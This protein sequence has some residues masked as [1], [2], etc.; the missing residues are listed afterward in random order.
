MSSPL[1]RVSP[2]DID[3][4]MIWFPDGE[5]VDIWG[6]PRFRYPFDRSTFHEDCRWQEFSSYCV[7]DP[8]GD[9]VAFG[10]IGDR[11]DRAH[12]AR[13]VVHPAH[14]GRGIGRQLLKGLIEIAAREGRY[15]SVALFVYRHNEVALGCYLSHGFEIQEYPDTA[16]MKDACFYLA[17]KIDVSGSG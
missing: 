2:A 6:G 8:E 14:R 1:D 3:E 5:S 17:R 10:Q 11:Y 7:R 16:P 12:L 9:A 4:L 15:K 13:L